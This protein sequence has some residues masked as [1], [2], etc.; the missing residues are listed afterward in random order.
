MTIKGIEKIG[1]IDIYFEQY[2]RDESHPTLVLLH[3]YLSSSFC[4]RKLI[5]YLKNQF[6]IIAIRFTSIWTK[7]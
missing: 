5:P 7:W 2:Q 6:N 4:Y 3:G 1:Q